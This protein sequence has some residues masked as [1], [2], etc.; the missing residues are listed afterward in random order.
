[1]KKN[2]RKDT[3]FKKLSR[4]L[5]II[6]FQRMKGYYERKPNAL[7]NFEEISKSKMESYISFERLQFSAS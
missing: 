4:N 6:C 7:L 3:I 1:M 2:V 5:V